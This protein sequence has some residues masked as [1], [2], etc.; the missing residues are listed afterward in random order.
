[1]MKMNDYQ[2][3]ARE[4]DQFPDHDGAGMIVPLLGLVGE[5]G[6]LLT[7]YKK[8]LRDGEQHARF[9]ERVGEELGDILW[10]VSTVA[11]KCGLRLGDLAEQN[12]E[13]T[14]ARWLVSRK[15]RE[16][17]DAGYPRAQ[18]LPRRFRFTLTYEQVEGR[19][20]VVLLDEHGERKGDPLT[21]NAYKSDGY[22]FHDVLHLAHAAVLGWSPVARKLLGLKR[23]A[24]KKVDEVE[25]GGRAQVLEEAIAAA[26]YAYAEE[27]NFLEGSERQPR[28]DWELLRTIKRLTRGREV[29]VCTEAEWEQAII[30]GIRVWKQ[31]ND[32]DGGTVI[33]ELRA[34]T[35]RFEPLRSPRGRRR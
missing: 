30:T 31:V 9:D 17:F 3:R 24:N 5:A 29:D 25:D 23:K 35:L 11:T 4:T 6:S 26:I 21:D 13:K 15:P 10:Y 33:G 14:R 1:M 7:E 16:L 2:R 28:V 34:R 12:I 20:K 19:R 32:H 22:R 18:Q 8:L 27:N